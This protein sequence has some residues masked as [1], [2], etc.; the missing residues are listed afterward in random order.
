MFLNINSDAA[1]K[2]TNVLEGLHRSALP[3][4]IRETLN[5]AAFDLKQNT[6]PESAANTFVNRTKTF[7]KANSKVEMATGFNVNTMVA[8]AGFFENKLVDQNTN[9]SVKDLDEQEEGGQINMKT[10]IPTVFARRGGTKSGLVKSQ[11]RLKVIKPKMINANL[12]KGKNG[13]EKYVEAA[14]MAGVGGFVIYKK[15]VWQINKLGEHS[16]VERTPIYSVSKGRNVRVKGTQFMRLASLKTSN[17]ME[18]YYIGQAE[19]QINRLVRRGR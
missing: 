12:L 7:F 17:K 14:K 4:A 16:A 10:F 19:K 13:R 2:F 9:W 5:Q 8:T 11:F 6:M 15:M 1:V 3:V 18:G